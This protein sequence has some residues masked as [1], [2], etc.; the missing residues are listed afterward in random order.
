MSDI[1][2]IRWVP[3]DPTDVK[4]GDRIAPLAS[5][6]LDVLAVGTDEWVVVNHDTMSV[7]TFPPPAR[8]GGLFRHLHRLEVSDG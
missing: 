5:W 4:A 2:R 7:M 3:V 6:T 8:S 1:D